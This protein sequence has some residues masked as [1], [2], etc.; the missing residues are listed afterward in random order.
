MRCNCVRVRRTREW[1]WSAME[2]IEEIGLSGVG[3]TVNARDGRTRSASQ[4]GSPSMGQ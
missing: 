2:E 4:E 1:T 3:G